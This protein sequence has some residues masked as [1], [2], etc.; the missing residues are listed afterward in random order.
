MEPWSNGSFHG[1]L[2]VFEGLYGHE[3]SS[4]IG[5]SRVALLAQSL[6][7]GRLWL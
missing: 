4:A 6:W 3:Q 5:L 2:L 7:P 1:E